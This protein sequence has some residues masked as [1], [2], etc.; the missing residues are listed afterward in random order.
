MDVRLLLAH[1]TTPCALVRALRVQAI[2]TSG[3]LELRYELEGDLVG[4]AI[5]PRAASCRAERLWQHT[6]FEAFI[7]GGDGYVELNFSPSTEWAIYRFSSYRTG[8]AAV[9]PARAPDIAVSDD[10]A[11]LSLRANVDWPSLAQ[12]HDR[13]VL[14]VALAAVVEQADGRL[15][16][17]AL[18]HPAGK[19]DFHHA[20]GFALELATTGGR[21][22]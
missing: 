2:A 1:P 12:M 8:M 3:A 16:Y 21:E 11:C 18:A 6:C 9:E 4:L 7:A 17:W 20:D 10:G 5:P 14:R 13:P 19:P 15:S 22:R